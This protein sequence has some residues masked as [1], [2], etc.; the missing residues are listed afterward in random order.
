MIIA[1]IGG[2]LGNQMFCY[3]AGLA[4]STRLNTELLIHFDRGGREDRPYALE[5]FPAITERRATLRELIKMCPS[6]A[7]VSFMSGAKGIGRRH[8]F[9]RLIRKII[10]KFF[11]HKGM[12]LADFSSYSPDF[13]NIQ[14]NTFI[15]GCWESEKIFA[16]IFDTVRRKFTFPKECFDPHLSAR[17]K[18]CNSAALHVRR[19]DK[20]SSEPK[21]FGSDE[22]YIKL[23][24]EKLLSLTENPSF[25]VFSDDIEWC[26]KNLPLIHDAEYTFVEGQTPA[27]D[28]AV[29]SLCRHI[30]TGPSTF[31]WWAARLNEQPGKIIIAPDINLWYKPGRY[32]PDDRKNLLPERWIKIS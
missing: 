22:R 5:C 25:F 30:I 11:S 24:I 29:M 20:V 10:Y 27:Q 32:N 2:G 16:G 19:G 1:D 12:Y 9:R 8:L 23:A 3:A 13:E 14:D 15:K 4:A 7:I 21:L 26:R 17:V 31:S 18:N 28:M 6:Q